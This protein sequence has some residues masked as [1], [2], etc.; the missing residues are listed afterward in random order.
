MAKSSP[1]STVMNT[2]VSAEQPKASTAVNTYPKDPA[3]VGSTTTL[4]QPPISAI[5][6]P[7]GSIGDQYMLSHPLPTAASKTVCWGVM[8]GAKSTDHPNRN[9][10][11]PS[12]VSKIFI[13]HVPLIGQP[14]S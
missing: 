5:S 7:Q 3:S 14:T 12:W 9:P 2:A 6:K 13:V 4:E 1:A 11:S 8:S 10:L